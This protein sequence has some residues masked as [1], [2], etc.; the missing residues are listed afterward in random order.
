MNDIKYQYIEKLKLDKTH[1]L[2][3]LEIVQARIRQHETELSALIEFKH[4]HLANIK[5][6]TDILNLL[7]RDS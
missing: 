1:H 6:I 3:R 7:D 5:E 2:Q 4:R